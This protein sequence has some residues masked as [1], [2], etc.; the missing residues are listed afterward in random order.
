MRAPCPEDL[1]LWLAVQ[2][3]SLEGLHIPREPLQLWDLQRDLWA[4]WLGGGFR[5]PP[6]VEQQARPPRTE[7]SAAG[8]RPLSLGLGAAQPPLQ[9]LA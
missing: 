5:E 7:L 3:A 9:P 1:L 2:A 4:G 6:W 8:H